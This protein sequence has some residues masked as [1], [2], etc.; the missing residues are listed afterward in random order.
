[1][2]KQLSAEASTR[3]LHPLAVARPRGPRGPPEGDCV[4]AGVGGGAASPLGHPRGERP[5]REGLS[6]PAQGTLLEARGVPLI[7]CFTY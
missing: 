3:T 4:G 6:G 5:T 2:L 7:C 1:M